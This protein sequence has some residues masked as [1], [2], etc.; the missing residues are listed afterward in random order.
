MKRPRPQRAA[1][2]VD[3]LGGKVAIALVVDGAVSV[4]YMSPDQAADFG[5]TLLDLSEAA[6]W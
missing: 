2:W 3:V 5:Q 4:V 1:M 6:R